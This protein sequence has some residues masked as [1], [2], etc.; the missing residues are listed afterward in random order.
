MDKVRSTIKRAE[1]IKEIE[2]Q[3]QQVA[4]WQE[5]KDWGRVLVHATC[6]EAFI[7]L[8]ESIE[9]GSVGGFGVR[10]GRVQENEPD[11]NDLEKRF[12]WLKTAKVP[13]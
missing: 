3:F 7:E 1:I 13:K 8:L 11:H 9:C 6:A 5:Y 10:K 4:Q 12:K 2:A